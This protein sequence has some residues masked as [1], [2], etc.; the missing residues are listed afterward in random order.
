MVQYQRDNRARERER[1]RERAR[2][3]ARERE[4]E[5]ERADS[6]LKDRSML[7]DDFL[8]PI[9]QFAFL[10]IAVSHVSRNAVLPR[11]KKA[12]GGCV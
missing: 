4:R 1:E 12:A 8:Y 11:L 3:R 5:R 2:E 7:K 6:S 10:E 9:A